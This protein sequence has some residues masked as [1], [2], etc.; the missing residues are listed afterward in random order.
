MVFWQEYLIVFWLHAMSKS[1]VVLFSERYALTLTALQGVIHAEIRLIIC[2]GSD[3]LK[4]GPMATKKQLSN[5]SYVTWTPETL[6]N[7]AGGKGGFGER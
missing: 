4:A 3:N 7:M 1:D 2:I 5:L 6:R